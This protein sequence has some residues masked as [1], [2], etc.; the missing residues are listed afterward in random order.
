MFTFAH[1]VLMH[2]A[3]EPVLEHGRIIERGDIEELVAQK[4]RS[5]KVFTGKAE[6]S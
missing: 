1:L 3:Q 6:L 5:S 4:G 2:R